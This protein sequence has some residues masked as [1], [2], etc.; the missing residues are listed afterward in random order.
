[1]NNLQPIRNREDYQVALTEVER[2]FDVPQGTPAFDRLEILITLVEAYENNHEP[3]V[4]FK[5]S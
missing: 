1:M 5:R 2:L 4:Y 3:I